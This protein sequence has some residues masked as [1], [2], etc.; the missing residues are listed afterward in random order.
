MQ[1]RGGDGGV[2]S[3]G[4]LEEAPLSWFV[5]S[6]TVKLASLDALPMMKSLV[7]FLAGS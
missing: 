7:T 4:G 3:E 1:E 2:R 6:T 5:V